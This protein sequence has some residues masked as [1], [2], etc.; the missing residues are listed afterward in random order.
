VFEGTRTV[1]SNCNPTSAMQGCLGNNTQTPI[2]SRTQPDPIQPLSTP[3][4][5]TESPFNS[6]V[7]KS[8]YLFFSLAATLQF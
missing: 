7:Y 2:G 1:G 8:H 5:Q 4:R 3:E 6:G